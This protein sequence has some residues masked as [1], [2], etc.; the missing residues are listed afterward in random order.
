MLWYGTF[1]RCLEEMGFKINPYYP[2]VVNKVIDEKQY[3]I[4]WYVNNN[5]ILHINP[6]V[7]D[8]VIKQIENNLEKGR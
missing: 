7:A 2:C 3:T 5:K 1:K 8:N 6:R 4:V